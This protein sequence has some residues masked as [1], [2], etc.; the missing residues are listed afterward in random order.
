MM[1]VKTDK[2]LMWDDGQTVHSLFKWGDRVV[3]SSSPLD[4]FQYTIQ[5][6]VPEKVAPRSHNL[7][8]EIKLKEMSG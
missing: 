7:A 8:A 2:Q 5:S 1:S 3:C 6:A 4:T